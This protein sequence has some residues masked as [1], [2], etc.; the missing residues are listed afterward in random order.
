MLKMLSKAFEWE[1]CNCNGA[2]RF[3]IA[4]LIMPALLVVVP[5]VALLVL[6]VLPEQPV[7][8]LLIVVLASHPELLAPQWKF[9]CLLKRSNGG[10]AY[11]SAGFIINLHSSDGF[12]Y[13]SLFLSLSC[14]SGTQPIAGVLREC[15][16]RRTRLPTPAPLPPCTGEGVGSPGWLKPPAPAYLS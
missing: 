9:Y 13:L 4:S 12:A 3:S 11:L 6:L 14:A 5:A 10:F 2:T 1:S 16:H 8:L 15:A 7:A